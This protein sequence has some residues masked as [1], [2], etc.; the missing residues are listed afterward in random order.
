MPV[1]ITKNKVSEQC[2][3][4]MICK[5]FPQEKIKNMVELTEGFFNVAFKISLEKRDVILKIAPPPDAIIMT[6]EK[7]IMLSEVNAMKMMSSVITDR[8]KNKEL[9][10]MRYSV[11]W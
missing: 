8:K 7:D 5:A 6:H 9:I 11:R 4:Q 3:E 1:S 10:G 2:I